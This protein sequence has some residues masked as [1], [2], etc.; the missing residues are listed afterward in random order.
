MRNMAYYGFHLV[1]F[2]QWGYDDVNKKITLPISFKSV[3]IVLANSCVDAVA[4][5]NVNEKTLSSFVAH[6][7][8]YN[9]QMYWF[10]I[11]K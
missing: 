1:L 11:G 9:K 5:L 10:A 7:S 4:A 2:R 3:S 8:N 6:I